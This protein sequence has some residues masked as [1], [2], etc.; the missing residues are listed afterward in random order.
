MEMSTVQQ[1]GLLEL[2][3]KHHVRLIL[4]FGSA[5]GGPMHAH[6]DLDIGVRLEDG[7]IPLRKRAEIALDLQEIFPDQRVD[8][9]II[10]RADP[11]FLKKI[12]ENCRLLY[13][14]GRELKELKI[15]A[16][17]RYQ[18]HQRVFEAERAYVKR[19]LRETVRGR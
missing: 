2:A 16:Y 1:R 15:Y 12:T 10:N 18:D 19:F 4:L 17:K 6:S 13:G 7:E 5:A 3:R 11:L 8:L 9:S 14:D